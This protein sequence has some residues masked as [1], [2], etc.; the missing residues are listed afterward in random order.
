MFREECYEHW[1]SALLSSLSH[2]FWEFSCRLEAWR[3]EH[4]GNDT[5]ARI[6]TWTCTPTHHLCN[7][8]Q[9]MLKVLIDCRW[10]RSRDPCPDSAECRSVCTGKWSCQSRRGCCY[11]HWG[12]PLLVSVVHI[13]FQVFS[14]HSLCL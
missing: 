9:G 11:S 7:S 10:C 12:N 6:L 3:Q 2:Y 8:L 4:L 5:L 13:R 14:L 1:L